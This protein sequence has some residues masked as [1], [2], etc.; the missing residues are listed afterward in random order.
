MSKYLSDPTPLR[1][2]DKKDIVNFPI[3]NRNIVPIFN[4]LPG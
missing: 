2:C 1:S 4:V 3:D